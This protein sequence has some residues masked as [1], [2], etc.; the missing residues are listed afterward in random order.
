MLCSVVVCVMIGVVKV[1]RGHMLELVKNSML[2]VIVVNV[3]IF[4]DKK[5]Y[6]FITIKCIECYNWVHHIHY[7]WVCN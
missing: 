1:T 5:S 7:F 6:F 3:T 4:C 2:R